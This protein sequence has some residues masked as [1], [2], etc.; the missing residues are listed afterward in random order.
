MLVDALK[1]NAFKPKCPT[2]D[3]VLHQSRRSS[4]MRITVLYRP[5]TETRYRLESTEKHYGRQ[6]TVFGGFLACMQGCIDR[7]NGKNKV[8]SSFVEQL[9]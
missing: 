4:Y 1:Y 2:R 6:G 7:L 8:S 5:H 9:R 3:H